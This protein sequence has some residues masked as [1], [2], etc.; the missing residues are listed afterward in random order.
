MSANFITGDNT[1][2]VNA[3]NRWHCNVYHS[4][5]RDELQSKRENR[6]R[7]FDAVLS[8]PLDLAL[9]ALL[10]F[11]IPVV[12][13]ANRV[14]L[15]FLTRDGGLLTYGKFAQGVTFGISLPSRLGMLLLYAPAAAIAGFMLSGMSAPGSRQVLVAWMMVAHFGKRSLES[16]FL[17]KYSGSMPLASSGCISFLYITESFASVRYSGRVAAGSHAPWGLPVGLALF[18]V[19]LVGNFYHHYLL[20]TLRKPGE[21]EYKV[22]RGGCFEYVAAP[23]YFFE[24]LGWAGVSAVS[25]HAISAGFFAGMIV[26][27]A[28]RA[29]AQSEW[30][31]LKLDNYPRARKHM[32]PFVF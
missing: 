13:L 15:P 1:C 20:A 27:L 12:P 14:N 18:G 21:K 8:E 2:R 29:V 16:L 4:V 24:L 11:L 19:G 25:Q 6:T 26:Y 31:R 30:N 28:D 22:P 17:H 7:R 5:R 10:A 9:V 3:T 32:V 23:H